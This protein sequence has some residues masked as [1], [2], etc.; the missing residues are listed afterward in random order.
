MF[1]PTPTLSLYYPMAQ[2][3][4]EAEKTLTNAVIEVNSHEGM[5]SYL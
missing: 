3:Y 1:T 4:S 5:A 2:A